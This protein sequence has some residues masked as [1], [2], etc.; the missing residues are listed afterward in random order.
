MKTSQGDV[1]K[2]RE[3]LI[4]YLHETEQASVTDLAEFFKVSPVTIRRDLLFLEKKKMIER[5]YG[6]V[7][8]L[9]NQTQVPVT[10]TNSYSFP[11]AIFISKIEPLVSSGMRIFIGAG[12]FSTEIIY[13]L[14]HL[15]V[16]IVTN[17]YSALQLNHTSVNA[18]ISICG[19]EL[20]KNSKALVGDFAIYSFNKVEA[21]LCI[22]EAAGINAHEVTTKTL[23]ES[24]I[25]RTMLQHTKGP[26]LTYTASNNLGSVSH[27][28][29]DKTFLFDTLYTDS[30]PAILLNNY[31]ITVEVLT[32]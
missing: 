12:L 19:G 13:G 1:F 21:D 29:I 11:T 2:R 7:K 16:E 22:I 3:K 18:V 15:E 14:A 10:F 8:L 20:E 9:D 31:P 28:M 30:I 32:E 24:F 17:D 27:F 6:G 23:N 5:F 25:Y 26:K 4:E